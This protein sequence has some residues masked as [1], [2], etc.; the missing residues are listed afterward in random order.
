MSCYTKRLNTWIKNSEI[1]VKS[2]VKNISKKTIIEKMK[3]E[4]RQKKHQIRRKN[5]EIRK[6]KY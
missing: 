1:L 4:K 5:N 6:I 3:A 2:S